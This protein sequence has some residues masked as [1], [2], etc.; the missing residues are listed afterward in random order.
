MG[1]ACGIVGLPNVGKSTLFNA[2]TN[3]GAAVQNFPFC[4]IDANVGVVPVRDPR[5][6]QLSAIV[7]PTRTTPTSM[8]F[9]DIAGL[10]QG[11]AQGEGLGN[12]FLS[13][14][15]EVDAI[16]HVVRCFDDENIAH[17][18]GSVNPKRDIEVIN[19]ELILADLET[20]DRAQQKL[21][22]LAKAGV[23]EARNSVEFL[24]WLGRR[25]NEGTVVR[26]LQLEP[27]QQ[28]T[29]QSI[30]LLT[31]KPILY[32]ANVAEQEPEN[33]FVSEVREIAAH[34]NAECVVICSVLEEELQALSAAERTEYLRELEI[35]E[36]GLD[37]VVRIGYSLLR[38]HHFFTTNDNEVR[39]WTVPVGT[40]AIKAAGKVHTDFERGFIRAEVIS[41]TDFISAEGDQ[42]AKSEGKMRLEG[43]DYVV[44]DGDVIYFR[45]NV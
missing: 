17:V 23:K 32:V 3:A 9:V 1:F 28:E 21:T 14:V 22:K 13:H 15:R 36:T 2:L 19:T 30:S 33:D 37:K 12:R 40:T 29:L 44:A 10:I 31:S 5:L 16:A 42:G 18:S 45:F 6:D 24:H 39:A 38:L 43:K 27:V 35:S 7:K 26:S 8:T 41:H 11:A 25:L 34:E 4:T 20:V